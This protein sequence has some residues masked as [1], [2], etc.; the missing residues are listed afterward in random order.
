MFRRLSADSFARYL[1]VLR[2]LG[3]IFESLC[4]CLP[5][6]LHGTLSGETDQV[7]Q[8]C[9]LVQS[10]TAPHYLPSWAMNAGTQS[11]H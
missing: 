5:Y 3:I 4:V 7:D 11:L 2:L 1:S 8:T 9:L 6:L 10:L